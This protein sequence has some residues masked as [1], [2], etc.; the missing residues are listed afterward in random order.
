MRLLSWSGLLLMLGMLSGCYPR[1]DPS[2]AVPTALL[3]AR[4]PAQ[5]LVVVLPGRGDG[6]R[7]LQRSGIAEAIQRQWPDADVVLTGLTVG[8]YFESDA[9]RR[10]HDEVIVPARARG[11]RELWL[12]GASLGGLGALMY[13]RA[14]P[15]EA[16]GLVLLAPY[17]GEP[18]LLQEITAAGGLAHWDAGPRPPRVDN[19]NFQHELWRHLQALSRDPAQARRLWVVFGDRDRLRRALPLLQPWLAPGHL[20]ERPGGHAW[21]VWTPAT[22][23]VLAAVDRQSPS[24]HA[25]P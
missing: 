22:S 15:G 3:P 11:Y 1:G 25:S 4:Q 16:D 10:L 23:E 17:L 14:W 18:P 9:P 6:L 7:G 8:Y 5:R 20:F 13:D 12:V 21:T 2:K 24:R 19:D